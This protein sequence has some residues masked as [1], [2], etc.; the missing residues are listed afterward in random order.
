MGYV[1]LYNSTVTGMEEAY[2]RSQSMGGRTDTKWLTLT[3]NNGKGVKITA[4]DSI[5][6]SALHFTDKDL[7]TARYGHD[8]DDFRRSEVVLNLDCIQRGLGNASCG[9][10]PRAQYEI[11]KGKEYSFTFRIESFQ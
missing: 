10:G 1:G 3:D 7:Y 5:S 9:P 2:V 4:K 8:I 6:F 11:E